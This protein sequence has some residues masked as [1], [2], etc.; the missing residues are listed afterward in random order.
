MIPYKLIIKI[1]PR[2]KIPLIRINLMEHW[3][4]INVGGTEKTEISTV[5]WG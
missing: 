5:V 1:T 4:L 2:V 3:W